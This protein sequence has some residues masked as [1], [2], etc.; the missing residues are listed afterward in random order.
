MLCGRGHGICRAVREE[1]AHP[2]ILS[3]FSAF[4]NDNT[5]L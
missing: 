5:S 3:L 4:I 1:L 2:L